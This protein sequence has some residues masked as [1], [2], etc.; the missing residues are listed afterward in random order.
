MHHPLTTKFIE[1]Y[2]ALLD[3]PQ[4]HPDGYTYC[5]NIE[6]VQDPKS[7]IDVRCSKYV[8]KI[9]IEA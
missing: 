5:V 7:L 8:R 1:H 4:T 6:G 3:Y 2:V 9:L